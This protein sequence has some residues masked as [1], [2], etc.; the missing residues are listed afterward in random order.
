MYHDYNRA[1]FIWEPNTIHLI[2]GNIRNRVYQSD[3]GEKCVTALWVSTLLA[4]FLPMA[5][6]LTHAL[7]FQFPLRGIDSVIHIT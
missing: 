6:K 7:S 4:R 5:L 1:S 2:D 3:I